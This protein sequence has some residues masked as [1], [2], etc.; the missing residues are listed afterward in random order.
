MLKRSD[1]SYAI[2]ELSAKLPCVRYFTAIRNIRESTEIGGISVDEDNTRE[3]VA[4]E[5]KD[6]QLHE[7]DT[8][9]NM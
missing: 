4:G 8:S 7:L 3:G 2:Y 6:S 9:A 5:K 1:V